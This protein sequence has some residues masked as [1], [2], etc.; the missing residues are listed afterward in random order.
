VDGRGAGLFRL[1]RHSHTITPIPMSATAPTPP[2]MPP[3][4]APL[5]DLLELDVTPF[6]EL[7]PA[8]AEAP[9]EFAVARGLALP[10]LLVAAA[11]PVAAATVPMLVKKTNLVDN[12]NI[13]RAG[14]RK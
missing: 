14:K 1:R 5:L 9:G 6:P 2:A 7:D 11:P 4:R 13:K 8:V 3:I 10:P 12:K